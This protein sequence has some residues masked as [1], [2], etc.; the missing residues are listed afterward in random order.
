MVA[1]NHKIAIP[2]MVL[3]TLFASAGHILL[4][5][6]ANNINLQNLRTLI[7]V[8]LLLGIIL[9]AS[10]S[11]FM[12]IAFRYGELS[13]LLP[14]LATSYVWVSLLSFIFLN[15]DSFNFWK[16]IGIFNIIVAVSLLGIGSSRR[17]NSL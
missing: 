12:M 5:Y 4:K 13:I 11:I 16:V 14:I 8:P 17:K 3:C 10:G 7:S 2:L 1:A 9:F 15:E 6:G